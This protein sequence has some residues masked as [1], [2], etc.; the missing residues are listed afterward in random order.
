ML[1]CPAKYKALMNS[2]IYPGKIHGKV[3][4]SPSKSYTHRAL[5]L[6]ALAKGTSVISNTLCCD[7]TNSTLSALQ[8]LGVKIKENRNTVIIQGTSGH[9][10]LPRQ[11]VTLNVNNSG[12]TLR[13]LTALCCLTDG[14]VKI[15][16]SR[17]LQERPIIELLQCLQQLGIDARANGTKNRFLPVMIRG[18]QLKGGPVKINAKESSQYVSALLLIAPYADNPI[19]ITANSLSSAPY[20]N[21][22]LD[23]MK[24]FDV[25]VDIRG[26]SYKISNRQKYQAK[27]Y[28]VEGDYSSAAYLLAAAAISKSHLTISSLNPLSVQGDKYFIKILK[29]MGSGS[30]LHGI[31]IDMHDYPDLVPTLAVVA[32]YAQGDTVLKNIGHLRLKESDRVHAIATQLKKMKIAVIEKEDA[33]II[34]GSKPKGAVID[35]YNDH[36][37]AMSFAIAALQAHGKTTIKNAEVVAKSYPNFWED[38]KNI[39]ANLSYNS[40]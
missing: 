2:I 25:S 35:T 23:L 20:V 1:P 22:T 37:I 33:L 29:M 36:R 18:G 16:G 15:T 27:D 4:A 38:L 40:G 30:T 39:G 8:S 19:T 13:L 32:A 34:S 31:E 14:E 24:Y 6:G 11:K 26:N 17:R 3:N 21:I 5:I 7:D 10:L 9:F 28:A 12:T